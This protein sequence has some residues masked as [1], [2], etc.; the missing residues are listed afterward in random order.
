MNQKN[1]SKLT[2]KLAVDARGRLGGKDKENALPSANPACNARYSAL[3][4]ILY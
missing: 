4:G 2:E 1:W 3:Y